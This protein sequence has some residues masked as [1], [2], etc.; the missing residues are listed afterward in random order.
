M[1]AIASHGRVP[2]WAGVDSG[3]VSYQVGWVCRF[4]PFSADFSPGFLLATEKNQRLQIAI[5]PEKRTGM[6]TS[7][8]WCGFLYKYCNLTVQQHK[9]IMIWN[10]VNPL[11][12]FQKKGWFCRKS[13]WNWLNES[14]KYTACC[15]RVS[16]SFQKRSIAGFLWFW[17]WI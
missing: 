14:N 13:L 10:N 6:K 17:K 12:D 4:L 3:S 1:R 16:E 5:Q 8:S 15:A 9:C 2:G 11:S 7:Q